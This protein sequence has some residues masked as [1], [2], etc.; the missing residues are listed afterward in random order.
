MKTRTF[1]PILAT[2]IFLGAGILLSSAALA[3]A[4]ESSASPAAAS[5][6]KTADTEFGDGV[7]VE[8]QSV[9][10]GDN[11]VTVKFKYTNNGSK[12]AE[13]HHSNYGH[14]NIAAEVYYIDPK[15]KKKYTPLKDSEG[16]PVA[17]LA[18][19][20]RL[21]PAESKA[22]WVKL[23]A[24]PADTATVTVVLPGAPPFEKVTVAAQ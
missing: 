4:Q 15:N 1:I 17:S 16:K 14:A 23:P 20:I 24:P 12:P 7:V 6:G 3:V 2:G 9:T 8:L 18:E 22:A 11:D 19:N 5:A 21:G 13:F 10:R